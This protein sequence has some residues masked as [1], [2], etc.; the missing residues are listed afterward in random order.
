MLRNIALSGLTPLRNVTGFLGKTMLPRKFVYGLALSTVTIRGIRRILLPSGHTI[1]P[2]AVENP[3]MGLFPV[4]RC[5]QFFGV[6]QKVGVVEFHFVPPF[7][8]V[9]S[10]ATEV[11]RAFAMASRFSNDGELRP[12]SIKLRKSTEILASSA[13]CSCVR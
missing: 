10:D 5:G 12:R 6:D 13:N 1:S 9:K 4:F 11:P 7:G 2:I 8:N 3:P